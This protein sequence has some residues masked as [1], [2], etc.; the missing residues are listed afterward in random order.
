MALE[1]EAELNRILGFIAS[2]LESLKG[3][4]PHL[5]NFDPDKVIFS[6]S[7]HYS[8]N[9]QWMPNPQYKELEKAREEE[10]KKG[11]KR[12]RGPIYREIPIYPEKDGIDIRVEFTPLEPVG[13][14]A[15]LPYTHIGNHAVEVIV[16]GADTEE[17]KEIREA[18]YRIIDELTAKA[19]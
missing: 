14:S 15:V 7:I 13:A 12:K 18:I 5:D 10:I 17:I 11:I 3:R 8:N 1:S 9:V 6:S 2:K 4:F 16:R 19:D